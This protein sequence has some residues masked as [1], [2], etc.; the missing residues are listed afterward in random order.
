MVHV[1][2]R[3]DETQRVWEV[4]ENKK[5]RREA[6][7]WDYRHSRQCVTPLSLRSISV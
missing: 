2:M 7:L 4:W 6:G 1:S 3:H 5:A